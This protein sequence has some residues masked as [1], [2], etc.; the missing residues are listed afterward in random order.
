MQL[1]S[2]SI[3][4]P[5]KRR[6]FVR[7]V[8]TLVLKKVEVRLE[9]WQLWYL[10]IIFLATQSAL[11]RFMFSLPSVGIGST[12]CGRRGTRDDRSLSHLFCFAS[13]AVASDIYSSKF[14]DNCWWISFR[15]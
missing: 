7:C 3:V 10:S 1:V 14:P 2:K 12:R 11:R 4:Y 5:F 13:L 15:N 6:F 8:C 9:S